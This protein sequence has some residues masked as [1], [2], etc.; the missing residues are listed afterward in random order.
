MMR[1]TSCANVVAVELEAL[2][3]IDVVLAVAAT[4]ALRLHRLGLAA[5]ELRRTDERRGD[6]RLPL[7]NDSSSSTGGRRFELIGIS[8]DARTAASRAVILS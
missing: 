3:H 1:S 5:T 6:A 7:G 2:H 8:L 4:A